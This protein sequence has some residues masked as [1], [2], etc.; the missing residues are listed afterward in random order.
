MCDEPPPIC[1]FPYIICAYIRAHN[2]RIHTLSLS[3]THNTQTHTHTL[4]TQTHTHI[5]THIHTFRVSRSHYVPFT[6]AVKQPHTYRHPKPLYKS[7]R[8]CVIGSV[9]LL[10]TL[11]LLMCHCPLIRRG[12]LKNKRMRLIRY[13]KI[14]SLVICR[15]LLIMEI[16][17]RF[18][19]Y[20]CV[21]VCVCVCMC[22]CESQRMIVWVHMP[23]C[24]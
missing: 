22:V 21:C 15:M 1:L 3:H 10:N 13:L 2:T 14:L 12:P 9:P 16:Q 8:M 19:R 11:C 23:V 20:V 24:L 6:K 5:H 7:L 4:N 18:L 17:T